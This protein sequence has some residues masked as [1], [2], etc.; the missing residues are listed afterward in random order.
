MDGLRVKAQGQGELQ[1]SGGAW[2][3]D[4]GGTASLTRVAVSLEATLAIADAEKGTTT[5]ED[6][7]KDDI[8]ARDSTVFMKREH[9]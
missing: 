8:M 6:S 5:P 3:V 7:F 2:G 4:F 9:E 1:E